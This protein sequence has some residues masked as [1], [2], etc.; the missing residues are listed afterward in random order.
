M[1][2]KNIELFVVF[3]TSILKVA[4]INSE[5]DTFVQFLYPNTG[6]NWLQGDFG[7]SGLPD[8]RAQAGFGAED[9]RFFLLPGSGTENVR[10]YQFNQDRNT[11]YYLE[12]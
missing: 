11:Y 3:F 10:Y 2:D 7:E 6:L 12:N 1:Q 9:G 5:Q 8:I 4:I